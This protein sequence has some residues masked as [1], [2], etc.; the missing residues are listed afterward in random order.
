MIKSSVQVTTSFAK[1]DSTLKILTDAWKS[2]TLDQMITSDTL[3]INV[4]LFRFFEFDF[5]YLITNKY[6]SIVDY[7]DIDNNMKALFLSTQ[8]YEILALDCE[9]G[10]ILE[11]GS[12]RM[13]EEAC[14]T[15]DALC[16]YRNCIVYAH[17]MP[18]LDDELKYEVRSQTKQFLEQES[19]QRSIYTY[20]FPELPDDVMYPTPAPSMGTKSPTHLP[21]TPLPTSKPTPLPTSKPTPKPTPNPTKEITLLPSIQTMIPTDFYQKEPRLSTLHPTIHNTKPPVTTS[22]SHSTRRLTSFFMKIKGDF[23]NDAENLPLDQIF[24]PDCFYYEYFTNSTQSG[25]SNI[26]ENG[27]QYFSSSSKPKTT[28]FH[29]SVRGKN[30]NFHFQFTLN[31]LFTIILSLF[32]FN[33]NRIM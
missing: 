24:C 23:A 14:D 1:E 5:S 18:D 19:N 29:M 8:D 33:F 7:L 10:E 26:I 31:V 3:D 22:L 9:E 2:F 25:I 20:R 13:N 12:S 6:S 16:V 32:F 4:R 27:F 21:T 17:T 15:R 28:Q 11:K 30:L